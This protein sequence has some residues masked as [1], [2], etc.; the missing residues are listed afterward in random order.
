MFFRVKGKPPPK[1]GSKF[2]S[3]DVWFLARE[4]S[5]RVYVEHEPNTASG[6]KGS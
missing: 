6:G 3:G 2:S 4:E 1:K 5:G